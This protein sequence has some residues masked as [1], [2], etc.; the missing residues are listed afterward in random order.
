MPTPHALV[1]I[2]TKREQPKCKSYRV[3]PKSWANLRPLN[4]NLSQKYWANLQV[5]GQPCIF[6]L[7]LESDVSTARGQT[8]ARRTAYARAAFGPRVRRAATAPPST[9]SKKRPHTRNA[10]RQTRTHTRDSQC[11]TR[12]Y[13]PSWPLWAVSTA[14]G[15]ASG[16][17][18]PAHSRT[19]HAQP[20][21]P[22]SPDRRTTPPSTLSNTPS[23]SKSIVQRC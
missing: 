23:R 18:V 15:I 16:A 10:S 12:N 5:L 1:Q 13:N 8:A 17:Q 14:R 3:G 22:P 21:R 4:G 6:H 11:S 19:R 9:L 7:A 2:T 20:A